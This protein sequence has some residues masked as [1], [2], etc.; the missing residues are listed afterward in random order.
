MD[1]TRQAQKKVESDVRILTYRGTE[2]QW[3]CKEATAAVK[4][5]LCGHVISPLKREHEILTVR[6]VFRAVSDSAI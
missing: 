5:R 4:E 6:V 2:E 3:Q 1:K